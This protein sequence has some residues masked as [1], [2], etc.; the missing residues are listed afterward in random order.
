MIPYRFPGTMPNSG[1][2][3][4]AHLVYDAAAPILPPAPPNPP[5]NNQ[6]A[7][8]PGRLRK[9][10]VL[11]ITRLSKTMLHSRMDEQS[12]YY[13][14]SFPLPFYY[15]KSRI[16]YWDQDALFKWLSTAG[17]QRPRNRSKTAA[18]QG[19]PLD[20]LPS[21]GFAYTPRI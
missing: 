2:L 12:P 4:T 8:Y 1:T 13:D 19:M 21:K 9:D 11:H 20:A 10:E 16:P 3:P 7:P 15:P 17:R 18:Q 5:L 14:E 6:Q